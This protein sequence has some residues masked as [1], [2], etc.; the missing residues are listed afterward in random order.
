MADDLS[1]DRRTSALLVMDF[2][3]L[4]VDNYAADAKAEVKGPAS[5]PRVDS[6]RNWPQGDQ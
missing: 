4:I 2:Q 6:V 5:G 1:I 3:K